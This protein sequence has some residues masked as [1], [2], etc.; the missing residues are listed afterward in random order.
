MAL[1]RCTTEIGVLVCMPVWVAWL[2]SAMAFWNSMDSGFL[3]IITPLLP[4]PP[5][6]PPLPPSPF[7]SQDSSVENSA[8][9]PIASSS[10]AAPMAPHRIAADIGALLRLRLLALMELR[11][12]AVV[13]V[14]SCCASAPSPGLTV[15]GEEEGEVKGPNPPPENAER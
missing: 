10:S 9:L 5:T 12:G 8:A 14:V 3:S 6:T 15:A 4:L 1:R 7:L 2:A 11:G 13:V